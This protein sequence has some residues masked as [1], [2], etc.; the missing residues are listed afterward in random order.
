MDETKDETTSVVATRQTV[1][2]AVTCES[3]WATSPVM[4]CGLLACRRM[5]R[6]ERVSRCVGELEAYAK[7]SLKK[8]SARTALKAVA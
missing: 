2:L 5:G 4:A 6:R 7:R 3:S 8:W 1:L